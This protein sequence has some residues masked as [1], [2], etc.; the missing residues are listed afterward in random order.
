MS[1]VA[2]MAWSVLPSS[3]TA[4]ETQHDCRYLL[5][6]ALHRSVTFVLNSEA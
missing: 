6:D 5:S 1:H 2:W 4:L 3:K